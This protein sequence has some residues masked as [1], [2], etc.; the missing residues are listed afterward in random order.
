MD[1][2]RKLASRKMWAAAGGFVTAV[3]TALHVDGLT[4]ERAA[5]L[6]GALGVLAAYILGEGIVDACRCAGSKREGQDNDH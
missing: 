3:M 1:W 4:I 6:T 5:T 2:K